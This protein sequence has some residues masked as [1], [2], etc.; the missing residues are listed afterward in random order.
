MDPQNTLVTES[1]NIMA[2]TPMV[3]VAASKAISSASGV[4]WLV[5]VCFLQNQSRGTNEFLPIKH[6]IAPEV[7][8]ESTRLPAKSAS[9]KSTRFKCS[10]LSLR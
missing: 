7:L 8:C 3:R 4:L 5:A 9:V 1:H 2:G 10:A 6:R